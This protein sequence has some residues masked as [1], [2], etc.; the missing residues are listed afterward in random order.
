MG[1]HMIYEPTLKF[2][3]LREW[4]VGNTLQQE[5]RVLMLSRIDES[6]Y[7]EIGSEWRDVPVVEVY[8]EDEPCRVISES[9]LKG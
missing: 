8:T 7:E 5:V 6:V 9:S 3:W 1:P 4:R 2:R